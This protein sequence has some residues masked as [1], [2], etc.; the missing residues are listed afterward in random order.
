TVSGSP[1]RGGAVGDDRGGSV[2]APRLPEPP[3]RQGVDTQSGQCPDHGAVDPDELQILAN[4]QFDE[5]GRAPAVPP[6]DGVIDDPGQ[7]PPVVRCQVACR[8]G[9]PGIDL[10]TQLRI[11]GEALP[12]L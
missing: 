1:D 3:L 7:C 12:Q 8:I 9:D 4:V 11:L 10:A 5:P 6:R 2:G